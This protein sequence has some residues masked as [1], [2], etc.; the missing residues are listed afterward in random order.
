MQELD[1][2]CFHNELLRELKE[3]YFRS[4]KFNIYYIVSTLDGEIS[5]RLEYTQV[6]NQ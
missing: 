4:I 6:I 1:D 2:K 3:I 5:N